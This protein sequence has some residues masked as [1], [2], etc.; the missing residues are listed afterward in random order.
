[1]NAIEL[2]SLTKEYK[3]FKLD[4]I[5]LVLPEGCIMGLIGEN[6]AGK[7]TTIKLIFDAIKPSAGEVFVLGKSNKDNF[8]ETK[9][10]IGVVLDEAHFPEGINIKQVNNI[11]KNTYKNW[12]E[13]V[14]FEYMKRFNLP[15][16]KQFKEFSRGMKMKLMI[17]VALSHK[18]KLLILDE[19]TSGLDPI[20][21]DEI[22]ELFYEFT[23]DENHSILIS[24]HI[25][26]DLEKLCDYIA[27]LHKG[28][29]LF[30]EEK[31]ILLEEYRMLRCS[32]ESFEDIDKDAVVG[33][34]ESDYGVEAL[35]VKNKVN[36][37]FNLEKPSIE[38]IIV[39]MAK[40]DI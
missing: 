3:D 26:S 1:M 38:D 19:A 39:F 40:E 32:K 31:D 29:L 33:L 17:G 21:R 16:N 13:D 24:S 7:S 8:R 15:L 35:V 9:E 30:V 2:K 12:Q 18:A 36:S 34:R 25:V 27:F 11:M 5:N 6:G 14:F 22:V 23:R 37:A 28:K 20:V 10:D 4:N